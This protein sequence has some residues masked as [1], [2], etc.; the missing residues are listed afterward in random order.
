MASGSTSSSSV[1][2]DSPSKQVQVPVQAQTPNSHTDK[3]GHRLTRLADHLLRVTDP[4]YQQKDK[5]EAYRMLVDKLYYQDRH[6]LKQVESLHPYRKEAA[7]FFT[8][9]HDQPGFCFTRKGARWC[10]AVRLDLLGPIVLGYEFP[11]N[12]ERQAYYEDLFARQEFCWDDMR[13]QTD[14]KFDAMGLEAEIWGEN[15]FVDFT[16]KID[17][18]KI[19]KRDTKP[20]SLIFHDTDG[21]NFRVILEKA[22]TVRQLGAAV[23]RMTYSYVASLLDCWAISTDVS[24]AVAGRIY[25]AVPAFTVE[26]AAEFWHAVSL[27]VGKMLLHL[28]RLVRNTRYEKTQE[29]ARD[30]SADERAD[31]DEEE[32]EDDEDEDEEDEEEEDDEGGEENEIEEDEDAGDEREDEDEPM[33]SQAS[34]PDAIKEENKLKREM[35]TES[36]QEKALFP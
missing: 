36:K 9:L 14:E 31:G 21:E 19:R 1:S 17:T 5:A 13:K 32:E 16:D 22:I 30:S 15:P 27:E 28:Y 4:Q 7:K 26:T 8:A 25:R 35:S 23:R 20:L 29:D 6:V 2:T 34:P 18:S 12:E 10:E 24:F 3:L 11:L 33:L